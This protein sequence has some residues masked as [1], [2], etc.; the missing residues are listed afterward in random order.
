MSLQLLTRHTGFDPARH[1]SD[2]EN[3][4]NA[5]LTQLQRWTETEG[6]ATW[7]LYEVNDQAKAQGWL[8]T[9]QSLGN[10]PD[11]AYFLRTA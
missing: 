1:D 2:A 4:A 11:A 6:S 5:G 7:L 3:R 9:D 10:A 8:K